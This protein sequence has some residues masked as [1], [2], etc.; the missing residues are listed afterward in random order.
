M[1]AV[2]LQ[3]TINLNLNWMSQSVRPSAF[4]VE[5]THCRSLC[6]LVSQS[7][8]S[9]FTWLFLLFEELEWNWEMMIYGLKKS[10]NSAEPH[11]NPIV[12]FVGLERLL[13][14][15]DLC[16]SSVSVRCSLRLFFLAWLLKCMATNFE[17]ER[18]DS[19]NSIF[20][21]QTMSNNWTNEWECECLAGWLTARNIWLFSNLKSF[22]FN[23]LIDHYLYHQI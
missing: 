17:R 23:L 6:H 5:Q 15:L 9:L 4:F 19:I 13:S 8:L 11:W 22:L 20:D 2:V 16:S 21:S 10:L 18:G 12:P 14:F 7:S 1:N 3:I